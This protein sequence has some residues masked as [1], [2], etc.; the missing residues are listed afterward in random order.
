MICVFVAA[1][2]G[3]DSAVEGVGG[4][5]G[6]AQSAS[7]EPSWLTMFS[8]WK[9]AVETEVRGENKVHIYIKLAKAEGKAAIRKH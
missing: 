2:H 6:E 1:G 7:A 8:P 9:W 4:G 3:V 5:S